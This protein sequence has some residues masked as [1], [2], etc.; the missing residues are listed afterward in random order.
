MKKHNTTVLSAMSHGCAVITNIDEYSPSWMIHG[1]SV[2]DIDKMVGF[3]SNSE[4]EEVGRNAK[5]AVAP[6]SFSQLSKII[7]Q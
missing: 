1:V 4:L 2:F 6:Y 5:Q 3:P 7:S